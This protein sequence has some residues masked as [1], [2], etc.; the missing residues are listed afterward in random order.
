MAFNNFWEKTI[1]G[2]EITRIDAV[3]GATLASAAALATLV[4]ISPGLQERIA[5]PLAEKTAPL[6]NEAAE[7]SF[8]TEEAGRRMHSDEFGYLREGPAPT[9][10]PAPGWQGWIQGSSQAFEAGRFAVCDL[11]LPTDLCERK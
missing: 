6:I 8:F 5:G 11:V 4:A 9:E 7:G 2:T 3:G 1:P 10:L